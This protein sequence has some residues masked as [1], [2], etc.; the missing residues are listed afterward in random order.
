MGYP[1]T[2]YIKQLESLSAHVGAR[3]NFLARRKDEKLEGSQKYINA[4]ILMIWLEENIDAYFDCYADRCQFLRDIKKY[5]E[6]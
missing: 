4:N 3:P 1:F 2:L 6:D 5:I